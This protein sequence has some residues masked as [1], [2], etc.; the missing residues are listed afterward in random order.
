MA[1]CRQPLTKPLLAACRHPGSY[2]GKWSRYQ[3]GLA[4]IEFNM[5]LHISGFDVACMWD[6]GAGHHEPDGSWECSNCG[7]NGEGVVTTDHM[8][9]S[10]LDETNGT[11]LPLDQYRLNPVHHGM[12]MMSQAQSQAMLKVSSSGYRLH[13][14]A[15]RNTTTGAVQMFLINKYNG[16]AQKVRPFA[17][18]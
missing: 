18:S 4:A 2:T 13:G 10:A 7:D 1:Q 16:T 12:E 6:N 17:G 3:K 5:E 14:F 9:L 8:L 15:S 11:H